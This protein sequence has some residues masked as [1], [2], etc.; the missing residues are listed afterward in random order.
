MFSMIVVDPMVTHTVTLVS[1]GQSETYLVEDGY[2]LVAE[3]PSL[4]G[5]TFKGW[6][7]DEGFQQQFDITTPITEDITLYAYWE[8]LLAFD[9]ELS[10][11]ANVTMI[12]SQPNTY[13]FDA[14]G[15]SD[16]TSIHWDL[17][18]GTTFTI[19]VPGDDPSEGTPWLMY[20]AIVMAIVI[21]G[22]L[23]TRFVI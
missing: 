14:S 9:S 17:G 11:D 10:A 21:I 2:T 23:I 8:G 16:Y 1:N 12:P 4:E 3:N 22:A 19:E 15:S 18:D 6:Y 13:L 5:H 20:A 7:L